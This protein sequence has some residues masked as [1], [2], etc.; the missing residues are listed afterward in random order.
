[1]VSLDRVSKFGIFNFS[2]YIVGNN[3]LC[4]RIKYPKNQF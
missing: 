1:M 3:K 4:L 2:S